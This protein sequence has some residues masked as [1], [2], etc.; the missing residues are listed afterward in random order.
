MR[1]E[2]YREVMMQL[3]KQVMVGDVT[4]KI[5]VGRLA[6]SPRVCRS[7]QTT[8]MVCP[9]DTQ[10]RRGKMARKDIGKEG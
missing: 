2:I 8:V 5:C 7:R 4:S 3:E 9:G 6:K 1:E 10:Q